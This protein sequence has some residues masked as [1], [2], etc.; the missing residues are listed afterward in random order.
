MS[1]MKWHTRAMYL[2][3]ALVLVTSMSLVAAPSQT[4]VEASP[5]SVTITEPSDGDTFSPCDDFTVKA[6]VMNGL[7]VTATN[8]TA[9]I[10][11]DMN[12]H[13]LEAATKTV[14]TGTLGVNA[15]AEVTWPVHC[16]SPGP[17]TI[18]VNATASEGSLGS[19]SITVTQTATKVEITAPADGEI[20]CPCENFGLTV[21]ISNLSGVS[22]DV[23]DIP[24]TFTP[25]DAVAI[26]SGPSPTLPKTISAGE[27]QVFT[28]TLHCEKVADTTITVKAYSAGPTLIGEDSVDVVQSELMVDI[29]MPE[30]GANI[31]ICDDFYV[32]V[33][34]TN[35]CDQLVE[36][37]TAQIEWLPDDG[38]T[39]VKAGITEAVSIPGKETKDFWWKLHC[40]KAGDLDITAEAKVADVVVGSDTVKVYQGHVLKITI[41]EPEEDDVFCECQTFAV[42]AK[43]KNKSKHITA[44]GV[45]GILD[46]TGNAKLIADEPGGGTKHS[47]KSLTTAIAPGEEECVIWTLHCEGPGTVTIKVSASFDGSAPEQIVPHTITV[48][49]AQ[50]DAKLSVKIDSPV[51]CD[52][53]CNLC[54]P[55]NKFTVT[56][57]IENE[58][59]TAATGVSAELKKIAGPGD[60][61]ITDPVKAIGTIP[62]LGKET[63]TWD[64]TCTDLG[65]V[66]FEVHVTSTVGGT[67]VS[68]PVTI[69]QKDF[70]VDVS[71]E[72]IDP[73]DLI[74]AIT[75]STC[76]D[77]TVTSR[78]YN[79]KETTITD[80]TATI[81]YSAV[82]AELKG[83]VV[84]ECY[85]IGGVL[86][87][88]YP[89]EIAATETVPIDRICSCCY[90]DVT[91]TL[92]C[93]STK[94]GAI[95]VTAKESEMYLDDDSVAIV[96][97][98]KAHLV[99]GIH[100][101]LG[102]VS[103][104]TLEPEQVSE[105][106]KCQDFT[107]VVPV[108]NI[109]EADAESVSV[110]IA[111]TGPAELLAGETLTKEIG[112]I[113][114]KESAKAIWELHCT[115]TGD[116]TI[117]VT[118]ISG[119]DENTEKAIT[120]IDI[121]CPI[122]VTQ[123]AA[124]LL[125]VVIVQPKDCDEF[126]K[127]EEFCVKA[128]VTN[129]GG[130]EISIV[131]AT[132]ILSDHP[133][134][135]T[136]ATRAERASYEPATKTLGNIPAGMTY[137][138][139]WVVHC[140][141]QGDVKIVV[142]A[143]SVA[144]ALAVESDPVIVHQVVPAEI[145]C[146]ILSPVQDSA[147]VATCQEFA[148]TAKIT[149]LPGSCA[150][151]ITTSPL[152][153]ISPTGAAHVV[154]GPTPAPP[155]TLKG[156]ES[157][158][159]SWTLHCDKAEEVGC[160]VLDTKITIKVSGMDAKDHAVTA[161]CDVTVHQ[162]PVANLVV[163]ITAPAD[164]S[165]YK[166]CDT[167]D[168]TATITNTGWA[169]AWDVS[170]TLSVFPEGSARITEGGYEKPVGTL[171]GHGTDGSKT[172]SWTLHCKEA[173]ESTIT[174]TPSGLDECGCHLK[175]A[176]N[177]TSGQWELSLESEPGRAIEDRFIEP[178]SITVKQEPWKEAWLELDV[179]Y[180][181]DGTEFYVGDDFAV[182]ATVTNIGDA[183]ASGVD[184]SI[185][186]G[187]KASVVS[188]PT[189]TWPKDIAAGAEA[190]AMWTL[191][192]D[193]A[194]YSLIEVSTSASPNIAKNN[195]TVKQVEP[196]VDVPVLAVDVVAPAQVY[197]GQDYQ[198][199]AIVTN[200]GDAT[201]T[202]VTATLEI[203]GPADTAEALEKAVG[204]IAA[205]SSK[206]RT[207]ELSCLD[208]GGVTVVVTAVGTG[209]NTAS[210][211]AAVQQGIIIWSGLEVSPTEGMAPLSITASADVS[212]ASNMA[213]NVEA[214][215]KV[216]GV[217]VDSQT[218]T[219]GSGAMQTATFDYILE[220]EGTYEV[221]INNLPAVTVEVLPSGPWVYDVDD[222]G[223]I[224]IDELLL[225]IDDYLN[226]VIDIS[227]LLQVIDLYINH[228][229]KP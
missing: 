165:T 198:V 222:S 217:V 57:T 156:G 102:K 149:N 191:S 51:T 188:G 214:E 194:G 15:T 128:K 200:E 66:T 33:V 7:N 39:E 56:A 65:D 168:V 54:D 176:Y 81:D 197:V 114:G 187:A 130:A 82:G 224:E 92:H 169:D 80:V 124:P 25:S 166:V 189:G 14:G 172:I 107:V 36:N 132:I 196:P 35:P 211:A 123:V 184:L 119:I 145:E 20:F 204:T 41:V 47:E 104:N 202:D 24:V 219:V 79:C 32:N 125:D 122:S 96:Q 44:T 175:Q 84:I 88:G 212:N 11:I 106:G 100:T 13:P 49:Q 64:V 190:V 208:A 218:V 75:V 22:I 167:F 147:Y 148:V 116:V 206:S 42:K 55:W 110:T 158:I 74:P 28:W 129:T 225:A 174:I 163:D 111:L 62:R 17:S 109:G 34:V 199:T 101:H 201:A 127:C 170:A 16:D 207:W 46:I 23:T 87:E 134:D 183:T 228:T 112:E 69:H 154:S 159:V 68:D 137:E 182:T 215:L 144:P 185:D 73:P 115:G 193:S 60:V 160:G 2:L 152:V 209:T 19:D 171:V 21:K 157:V 9:T 164:G 146:K 4:P 48:E 37:V 52:K 216:D 108:T 180:P 6:T 71:A 210:D 45:I 89:K 43:I 85:D 151:T 10:T 139:G 178:D 105:F 90:C 135:V 86:K 220:A 179:S 63:V 136:P 192:C 98:W 229:P 91:W 30:E 1:K 195:V 67:P 221:T 155:W 153:S 117:E 131:K 12:A 205:G 77:F 53:F 97:E 138:V 141:A 118:D 94:D 29:V 120:N 226:G 72:A 213:A 40:E 99:G 59:C 227:L 126:A 3:F 161:E 162:Y 223:Y 142:K 5:G 181:A 140:K 177:T 26:V 27:S 186:P 173:C 103:D 143:E 78:L 95:T 8:V 133:E 31:D 121:P 61:S 50:T 113:P 58:G 150:V 93:I 38:A 18:S 83:M 76:Q 203:N 70:I